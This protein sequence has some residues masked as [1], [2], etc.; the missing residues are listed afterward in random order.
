L[1]ISFL[2]KAQEIKIFTTADF[3]LKGEVKSCLTSTDYGKEEYD[4][5]KEGRLTK[6]LTRYN[7][8][9]Y[10]ITYYFYKEG[11]LAEKR[12]ENY[13][14]K[15]F[16]RSTS[17][18]N[19]YSIDT[20]D[21]KLVTE[22]IVSYDKVFLDQYQYYYDGDDKLVKIVRANN[23]GNDETILEYSSLKNENTVDYILNGV[24]QKSIRTSERSSKNKSKEK[25]ILTKEYLYGA[26]NQAIEEV[27]D[28]KAKRLEET[29]FAY[30]GN[31][32]RFSPISISKYTYNEEGYLI[33]SEMLKGKQTVIKEFVYQ[34]DR[35][36]T[37][38]WVKQII[39]PENAYT[40]RKIVYYENDK[41]AADH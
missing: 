25:V 21:N 6:S 27:F 22:K 8:A 19:F 32:A 2:C 11:E 41:V 40:S 14:D 1:F 12:L 18:A 29:R 13:R 5:D 4:F 20:T 30:D 37:G 23:N 33:K 36:K 39:K 17:I 15:A 28:A 35:E 38:N 34:F 31:T 7:D 24:L 9:D 16:D 3:D 26:P 10:D